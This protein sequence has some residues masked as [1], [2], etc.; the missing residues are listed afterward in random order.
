MILELKNINHQ[1]DNKQILND[2]NLTFENG[3]YALLGLNGA[4]KTTL[5]N[6]LS[7]LYMPSKGEMIYDKIDVLKKPRHLQQDLGY[8]SQNIGLIQDFTVEQNL[9]Y[10]GLLKGCNAKE[11]KQKIITMLNDFDLTAIKSTK[12]SNLSGGVKQRIG[13]ALALINSPKIII[14]D[15]PLNNLD[16]HEREKLY[17]LLKEVSKNCIIIISTHLI[18]EIETVCDKVIFMKE[19]VITYF[20]NLK[21][22]FDNINLFI[23]ENLIEPISQAELMQKFKLIKTRE[24]NNQLIVRHFVAFSDAP[25]TPNIEDAFVYYTKYNK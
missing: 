5:I 4:G 23:T 17:F 6:I 10:F 20:G 16:R 18:D 24:E 3:I 1:I 11:L 19:G 13:I 22:S 7:T 25:Y 8:M 14:L 21:S 9:Y 2:I 15:E 12:I